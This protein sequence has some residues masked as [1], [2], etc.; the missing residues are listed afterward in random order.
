MSD[1]GDMTPREERIRRR[2]ER[3]WNDLGRPSGDDEAI[4]H[5]AEAEIDAEDKAC[6]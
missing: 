1:G 3:I 6:P 5:Q 2:A 4:W